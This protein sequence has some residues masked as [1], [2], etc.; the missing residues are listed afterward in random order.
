[1]GKKIRTDGLFLLKFNF[2]RKLVKLILYSFLVFLIFSW[3]LVF[4]KKTQSDIDLVITKGQSLISISQ[5]LSN[6]N[7]TFHPRLF[8][9]Y[10][11]VTRNQNRVRAGQFN[12]PTGSNIPDI[13]SILSQ[14]G[15]DDYKLTITPGTRVE[16]ITS[17]SQVFRQEYLGKV[18]Y[19]FPET[20]LIPKSY[21]APRLWQIISSEFEKNLKTV[22]SNTTTNLS[23]KESIILASLLEREAKTLQDKKMVAGIIQNRLDINMP[24]QID[25][26]VQFARDTLYPPKDGNYWRPVTKAQLQIDSPFNTY[27]NLGLPPT[28]ICNPGINSIN[29]AL[30][31]TTSDYLFYISDNFGNLHFAKTLDQ[32]N[33]NINTYLR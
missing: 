1:M 29:A 13:L 19:M 7:A 23:I 2:M 30:H 17:L 3:Y 4:V 6:S 33:Q 18:G 21:D 8:W 16:E 9:A 25:A 26:T 27:Q 10:T 28:P 11:L 31:P 14:G 5:L 15:R 32:H 12:I 24:L 20:Y 22:S